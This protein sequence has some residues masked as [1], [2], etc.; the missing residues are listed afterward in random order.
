MMLNTMQVLLEL[1]APFCGEGERENAI[2]L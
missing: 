2:L 1:S